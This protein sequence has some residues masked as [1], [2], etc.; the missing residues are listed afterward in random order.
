V[1]SKSSSAS[2]QL[3][4]RSRSAALEAALTAASAS[5]AAVAGRRLVLRYKPHLT[6][7]L[8]L[9]VGGMVVSRNMFADHV[10]DKQLA[11]LKRLVRWLQRLQASGRRLPDGVLAPAAV[12]APPPT[13]VVSMARAR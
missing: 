12:T 2:Q 10:P 4:T 7:G 11:E 3:A 13:Q 5:A 9:V 1:R 6:D 8:C